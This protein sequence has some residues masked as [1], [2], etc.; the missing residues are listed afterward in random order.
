VFYKYTWFYHFKHVGP[1]LLKGKTEAHITAAALGTRKG[2]AVYTAAVNDVM[3]QT[4]QRQQWT[5]CF[6]RSVAEPC[7]QIADYCAWAIQR[8]WERGEDRW[9]KLIDD[10]IF[11]QYDLW[12]IG[13]TH[14]Y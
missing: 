11:T 3:Q 7:L 8:K 9:C 10:Q 13:S 2:Q 12:K 14:Y 5:T 4:V 1:T 6:P